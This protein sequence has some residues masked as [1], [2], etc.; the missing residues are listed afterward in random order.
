MSPELYSPTFWLQ[1]GLAVIGV[2]GLAAALKTL[3]KIE[4]QTKV[5]EI[6][7]DAAKKSA[8]TAEAALRLTQ[9]SDILLDQAQLNIGDAQGGAGAIV[10]LVFKNFGSTRALKAVFR[11]G[12]LTPVTPNK[13]APVIGPITLGP[14]DTQRITFERF[15]NW[16]TQD[17]AVQIFG[18]KVLL[19]FFAEVTYEDIFGVGHFSR[20]YGTWNHE[21]RAFRLDKH[22]AG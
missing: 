9:R 5:A 21:T 22:E 18:G 17:T 8:D 20:Y 13:G 6:A 1:L 15:G 2:G 14:N 4:R 11:T 12:L 16:M 7:A 19:Q 3:N 10:I